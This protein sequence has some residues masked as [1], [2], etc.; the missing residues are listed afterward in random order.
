MGITQQHLDQ[1]HADFGSRYGG[2][3]NDYFALLY[4]K[5][6]FDL[7]TE[8]AARQVSFG[9]NDYGFD[10]YH[11]EKAERNLFLYQFKWSK[12]HKL[13]VESLR[14]LIDAGMHRTFGDPLQDKGQ[15]EMLVQLKNDLHQKQAV[16]D[17]VFIHFV[18][19]GDPTAAE[20]STTIQNLREDLEGRKDLINSYFHR[21]EVT[22]TVAYVPNQTKKVTGI[23]HISTTFRHTITFRTS[24]CISTPSKDHLYMGFVTLLDLIQLYEKISS[25]LFER[26]I[27][28]GLNADTPPNRSIRESLRRIVIKQQDD[29]EVFAFN[30][31][32]ICMA[33][34]DIQVT[35]GQAIVVDPRILNG[36]QTVTTAAEF[37]KANQLSLESEEARDRLRRIWVPAKII[38]STSREFITTVTVCNNKQNHVDSWNLRANDLI[39]WQLEDK[40]RTDLDPGVFYERQ[41]NSFQRY[42]D[43]DMEEMDLLQGKAIE[44][45]R[46]AQTFLAAQGEVDKISSL[47]RVFDSD[48]IYKQTF[49]ESYLNSDVRRIILAYKIQF[50]LNRIVQE[51]QEKG[52]QKNADYFHRARN[53][54]WALLVQAV[55]N[56]TSLPRLLDLFGQSPVMEADYKELLKSLAA[57]RVRLLLLDVA[58]LEDNKRD[59]AGG[60]F[61]FLRTKATYKRCMDAAYERYGW[62]RLSL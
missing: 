38:L 8:E 57:H 27:R 48:D 60:N 45:K 19:N 50:N 3:V 23:S 21:D 22:L 10:G 46:L 11:I 35:D 55:L 29:P 4:L 43:S 7:T 13:F 34:A 61:G 32:G 1:A 24:G 49:R 41:Q 14:R 25:R 15:N 36:A 16:V 59:I 52:S 6:E 31:N 33:V 39:Q 44:I 42:L 2:S 20:N 54:V 17:R 58:K 62:K 9:P 40:F 5:Q 56:S 51:I 26:N 30:H 28:Y 53:L 47:P 12:D 37:C 18:F